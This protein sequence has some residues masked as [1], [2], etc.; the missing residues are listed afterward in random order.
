LVWNTSARRQT[1]SVFDG[2]QTRSVDIDDAFRDGRWIH[3]PLDVPA[4]T[5]VVVT[6]GRTAGANAVIA[7]LFLG[8][9]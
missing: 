6:G 8:T 5:T 4:G 1:V 9:E 7:G 3:A 2:T